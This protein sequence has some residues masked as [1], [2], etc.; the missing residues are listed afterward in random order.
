[1]TILLTLFFSVVTSGGSVAIASEN[2]HGCHGHHGKAPKG[3][4]KFEPVTFDYADEI[5]I[6]GG[7][8]ITPGDVAQVET[9]TT[10]LRNGKTFAEYR[11][12]TTNDI[13]A[14]DGRK[15]E[16]LDTG[17]PYSFLTNADGQAGILT[18][19][20]PALIYPFSAAE[21]DLFDAAGLPRAF[22][23]RSGTFQATIDADYA[24]TGFIKVPKYVSVCD[25]FK[26]KSR[27]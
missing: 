8:T 19:K 10:I 20:A 26:K 21:Q 3:H 15:I 12:R 2:Q 23:F 4:G 9:R 27:T 5:D 11:G 22:Y 6:C 25:L 18:V 1:M 24:I 7:I 13:V 14:A 17:G 16:E